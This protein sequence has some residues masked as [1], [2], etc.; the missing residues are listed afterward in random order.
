MMQGT[1]CEER[2]EAWKGVSQKRR[3]REG[4][5]TYGSDHEVESDV[6]NFRGDDSRDSEPDDGENGSR[7]TD[8]NG[9]KLSESE[10]GRL[11]RVSFSF[12]PLSLS[13]FP[14]G[15]NSPLNHDATKSSDTSVGDRSYEHVE[16][17]EP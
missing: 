1:I 6:G 13:L 2:G 14:V 10:T 4:W 15:F 12:L 3:E 8:E 9:L 11:R 7:D 17:G 16:E 5:K